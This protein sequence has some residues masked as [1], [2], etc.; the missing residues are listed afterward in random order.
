MSYS[1][2]VYIFFTIRASALYGNSRAVIASLATLASV[3]LILQGFASPMFGTIPWATGHGPCFAGKKPDASNLVIVFWVRSHL[4]SQSIQWILTDWV[5]LGFPFLRNIQLGPFLFDLTATILLVAR[6]VVIR[7]RG[8][9]T[10]TGI[11]P[12]ILR[13]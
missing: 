12:L 11:I 8:A 5:I 6:I 10:D 13:E 7:R 3:I 2:V 9:S 4:L 1:T